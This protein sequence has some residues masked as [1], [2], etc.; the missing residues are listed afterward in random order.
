V[1]RKKAGRLQFDDAEDV[2]QFYIDLTGS[3]TQA[4]A[5]VLSWREAQQQRERE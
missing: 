2:Y 1:A 5:A 3:V 4:R